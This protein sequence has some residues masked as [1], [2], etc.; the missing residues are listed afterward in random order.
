MGVACVP[1]PE[2]HTNTGGLGGYPPM[3][4]QVVMHFQ[5]PPV[6]L[7]V[8]NELACAMA[9]KVERQLAIRW[10]VPPPKPPVFV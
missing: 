9:I 8:Y 6:R 3:K 2:T 7:R 5:T 1:Q 4:R 10:G